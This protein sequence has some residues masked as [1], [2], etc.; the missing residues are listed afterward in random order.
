[1]SSV[2]QGP[3]WDVGDMFGWGKAQ[4][5][6]ESL[7]P[8]TPSPWKASPCHY[9]L[10]E[11]VGCH[12]HAAATHWPSRPS[13]SRPAALPAYPPGHC[14]PTHWQ[15]GCCPQQEGSNTIRCQIKPT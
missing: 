10:K 1:V 8:W 9:R 3:C 7:A 13:P 4:G 14:P 5:T 2:N 6:A 15:T 11:Q 12:L